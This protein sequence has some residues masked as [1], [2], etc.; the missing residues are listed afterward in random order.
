MFSVL[1]E[2]VHWEQMGE[3]QFGITKIN[4]PKDEATQSKF[5]C[6]SYCFFN[7]LNFKLVFKLAQQIGEI[8]TQVII[9]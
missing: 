1:R 6:H 4:S 3:G 8:W 7:F 2:R 5:E 9:I